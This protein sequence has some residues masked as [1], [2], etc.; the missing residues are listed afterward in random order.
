MKFF[1][2]FL[3]IVTANSLADPMEEYDRY[4]RETISVMDNKVSDPIILQEIYESKKIEQRIIDTHRQDVYNE[5]V[6][7]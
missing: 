1:L 2:L 7:D 3:W 5:I 6:L 4:S